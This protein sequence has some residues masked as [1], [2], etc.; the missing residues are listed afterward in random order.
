MFTHNIHF[1]R[2]DANHSCHQRMLLQLCLVIRPLKFK[3][4]IRALSELID[5]GRSVSVTK[6]SKL[7]WLSPLT[8]QTF[9]V[10]LNIF[11]TKGNTFKNFPIIILLYKV[12]PKGYMYINIQNIQNIT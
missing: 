10:P 3:P 4:G 7:A 9:L 1:K 8:A 2:S 5:S 11:V 6:D 12:K